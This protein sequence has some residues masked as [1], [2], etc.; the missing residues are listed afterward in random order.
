V[1][2]LEFLVLVSFLRIDFLP[3]WSPLRG[4]LAKTKTPPFFFSFEERLDPEAAS[5]V[6]FLFHFPEILFLF[7]IVE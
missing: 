3:P 6:S 1:P 7:L 5:W 2:T 4:S